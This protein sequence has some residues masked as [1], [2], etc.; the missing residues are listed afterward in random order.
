M[1]SGK[2]LGKAAEKAELAC[3]NADR[4]ELYAAYPLLE[5]AFA[6]FKTKADNFIST[7]NGN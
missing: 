3:K 4:A 2:E 7:R 1:M 5:E 6:R